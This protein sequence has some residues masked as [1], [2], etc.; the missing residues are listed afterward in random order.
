MARQH[1]AGLQDSLQHRQDQDADVGDGEEGQHGGGAEEEPGALRWSWMPENLRPFMTDD[2]G[3]FR[4]T[5][6]LDQ[7]AAATDQSDYLWYR[8]SL[9]HKGEGAYKLYVNTTG[10]AIYAFVNGKLVGQNH[11][12]N[13]AFVFQLET[14]VKLQSGKNYIS[15][16]SG[17]VDLKNYGPLFE[18]MPA[19]IAGG[20]VK[21][22]G[23]NGTDIDLTNS[24]WFYKS[25][26]AG[27]QRQIHL[28]KAGYKWRSHN[29]SGIPVNRPFTWYK[30]TFAAP[31][32]EEAVVVD[33]L[34]L[35]KGA[36]WVNSNSL[37][38]YWPSYTA[39]EMD[40]C[41]VCDYRGEFKAEGGGIRCLT[42]VRRAVAAVLPRAPRLPP[43]RRAQHAGPLRGG[44]RRPD[45][46]RVP[47]GRRGRRLRGGRRGRGRRDA[48]VR[49]ARARGRQRGRGQ[50]RRDQ[51]QLRRLRGRVRVL[52]G[53]Q[54][55]HGGVRRQGVVH[56]E[57]HGR[58]RRGRV[59]V[60][61]AHRAG[62]LLIANNY[63]AWAVTRVVLVY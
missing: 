61:R 17:T 63:W 31:A 5:Q 3:S 23:T 41:H 29:S 21:L 15:L 53:A 59:R 8:T 1:L 55:V 11:S 2:R 37:G 44:R 50:L 45:A 14:P 22:V 40:G 46:R 54:G 26:L 16:L 10:H 24:S 34:G 25:G 49:R 43:R 56:G 38:R 33:L 39:A 4:K 52:G 12:T 30:T 19:G 13:G 48:G 62:H 57:A 47:H 35:N 51:G 27:E 7:I 60:R 9:E 58:V 20:P 18:L 32:G 42:G 6:L 36:A 28:D